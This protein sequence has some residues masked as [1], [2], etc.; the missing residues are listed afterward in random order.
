[1]VA[2]SFANPKLSNYL[3]IDSQNK[4][5]LGNSFGVGTALGTRNRDNQQNFIPTYLQEW[6]E[7]TLC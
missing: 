7:E 3:F 1:M 2:T 6:T 4:Y 5:V